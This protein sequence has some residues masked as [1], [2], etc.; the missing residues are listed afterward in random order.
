MPGEA[1]VAPS[2]PTVVGHEKVLFAAFVEVITRSTSYV[3]PASK[4]M[5]LVS[6]QHIWF[7]TTNLKES[8]INVE[9]SEHSYQEL[10]HCLPMLSR[11]WPCATV[12][13]VL[14]RSF[15][16]RFVALE[17]FFVDRTSLFISFNDSQEARL[18]IV[19]RRVV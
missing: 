7:V 19:I 14:H 4:G 9:P 8:H 10:P 12:I 11:S 13:D 6:Q 15:Q 18:D 5:L 2:L 1:A 17:L 3:N 16:L